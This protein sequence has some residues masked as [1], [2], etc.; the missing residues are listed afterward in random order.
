MWSVSCLSKCS[1]REERQKVHSAVASSG[2]VTRGRIHNTSVQTLTRTNTYIH[3][4]RYIN[5][6][7]SC[8]A[9]E[10]K[11]L[12]K[13]LEILQKRK[14][15]DG[16]RW[17]YFTELNKY[18]GVHWQVCPITIIL[19]LWAVKYD[20]LYETAWKTVHVMFYR[21]LSGTLTQL[22]CVDNVDLPVSML[23]FKE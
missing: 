15:A 8:L 23:G 4:R 19:A 7:L 11:N 17:R 18:D 14:E 10:I 1:Y 21:H 2:S 22:W 9:V 20:L 16:H 12:E 5:S 6:Y 13:G 3:Y